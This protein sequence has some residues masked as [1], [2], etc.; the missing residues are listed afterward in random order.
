MQG[1]NTFILNHATMLEALQL[2]LAKEI[3]VNTPV[4]CS[5]KE[6][7]SSYAFLVEVKNENN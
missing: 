7:K 3:P 5:I 4:V 6:D 2:W 1:T